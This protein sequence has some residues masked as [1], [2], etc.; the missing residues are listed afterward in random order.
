MVFDHLKTKLQ[1]DRT[2]V[3]ILAKYSKSLKISLSL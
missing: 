2:N 1:T 3:T